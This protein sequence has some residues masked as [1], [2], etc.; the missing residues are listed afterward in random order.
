MTEKK[1]SQH[2]IYAKFNYA[3]VFEQNKD[4]VGFK[5]ELV[6]TGGECTVVAFVDKENAAI[7]KDSGSQ[8]KKSFND[9]GEAFYKFK[10][11][12]D[13]PYTYGGAPQ[14]AKP[15]GSAWDIDVDGLIGNGSEGWLWFS[16]YETSKGNGTRLDAIQVVDH[17]KYVSD[18]PYVPNTGIKF[19]NYTSKEEATPEVA[20]PKSK[21]KVTTPVI[22]DDDIPF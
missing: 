14:V 13:A 3:R 6:G 4:K 12:W 16:V 10:R 2:K 1:S 8:L 19:E 11:K 5:D 20:K 22:E 17:I 21:A 18:K 9:D 15:D 7:V